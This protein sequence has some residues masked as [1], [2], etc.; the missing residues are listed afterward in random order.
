MH[1]ET[2][3]AIQNVYHLRNFGAT[4]TDEEALS[5][6]IEI[7]E[8]LALLIVGVINVLQVVDGVRVVNVTA[9]EDVGFGT[10][11]D[12]TPYT[13]AGLVLPTQVAAGLNLT[14]ERLGVVGRKFF[15]VGSVSLINAGGIIQND[16]LTE[17]ALAGEYLISLQVATETDWR[18]GVVASLDGEFLPFA[19]YSIPTMAIIQRRR[20]LG[21]GI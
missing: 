7:L 15:G 11:T 8:A 12:D 17:L 2:F 13:A 20:R 4:V 10:F 18:F 21:V 5:D 19:G 14:T 3:G 6:V 9:G 16:R 1:Y